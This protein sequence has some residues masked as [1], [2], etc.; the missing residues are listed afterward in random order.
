MTGE[1]FNI[2]CWQLRKSRETEDDTNDLHIAID[3]DD[4]IASLEV[5]EDPNLSEYVLECSSFPDKSPQHMDIG[6]ES[7]MKNY[8][9]DIVDFERVNVMI[10]YEDDE[11]L[12]WNN[13]F[14]EAFVKLTSKR[15]AELRKLLLH[16]RNSA[17]YYDNVIQAT[18][19]TDDYN[20]KPCRIV[21]WGS[22]KGQV[23]YY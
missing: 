2:Y 15:L 1:E 8:K 20:F 21:V 17:Y 4:V 7:F 16:S 22:H 13:G 18:R 3:A 6:P 11:I 10:T 12:I 23:I 14:E 19:I 5:F 9:G